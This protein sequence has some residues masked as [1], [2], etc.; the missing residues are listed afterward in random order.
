MRRLFVLISIGIVLLSGCTPIAAPD[1]LAEPAVVI[2][3]PQPRWTG[4]VAVEQALKSRRSVRSFKPQPISLDDVSQLLW[5]AQ[6]IKA[7]RF[8]TAP[9][10]GALYP[11]EVYIAVG[12]VD[13]LAAGVYKYD[14]AVHGLR[15]VLK[16]DV[17]KSL[18]RVALRQEWVGEGAIALVFA[19][20]YERT[21]RK[22]GKRG[23]RYVHMEAGHAAQ[24]V[25]LQAQALGLGTVLV[26][27]FVDSRVKRLLHMQDAEQPL[28]IM[29]V[30]KPVG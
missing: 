17:R 7:G 20:V 28:S 16:K 11:L 25:Y 5:A 3:L 6:G 12:N 10:A 30:G 23:I 14:P 24:N 26:G 29:P 19:A 13:G 18:A 9:S 8:R 15:A 2:E 21:T 22:Y 4:E 27:A 1:A